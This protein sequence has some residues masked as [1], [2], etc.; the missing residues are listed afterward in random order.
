[1]T[2]LSAEELEKYQWEAKDKEEVFFISNFYHKQGIV[3]LDAVHLAQ[4]EC[5]FTLF[6]NGLK[7]YKEYADAINLRYCDLG[8][9]PRDDYLE[10]LASFRLLVNASEDTIAESLALGTPVLMSPVVA[11]NMGIDARE[12][13][14][15]DVSSAEEISSLISHVLALDGKSYRKLC[16]KGIK[17]IEETS[18]K[19]NELVR[20]TFLNLKN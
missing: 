4:K 3:M 8:A 6:A 18:R 11:K 20:Q 9:L 2:S 17:A 10:W 19:N 1:M 14:V 16:D 12:L 5:D 7:K 13:I 15:N